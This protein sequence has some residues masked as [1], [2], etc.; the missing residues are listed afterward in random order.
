MRNRGLGNDKCGFFCRLKNKIKAN[1]KKLGVALLTGNVFVIAPVLAKT[2]FPE[3]FGGLNFR[4][5]PFSEDNL[6]DQEKQIIENWNDNQF[7][8]FSLKI[9]NLLTGKNAQKNEA[10]I[11]MKIYVD[12]L[13]AQLEK[14]VAI[15]GLSKEAIAIKL[16]YVLDVFT[17][18]TATLAQAPDQLTLVV[19]SKSLS[20]F[21]DVQS[22]LVYMPTS[23][24]VKL[25]RIDVT[26]S[27][28]ELGPKKST[29]AAEELLNQNPNNQP[30]VDI[31]EIK[32]ESKGF[33]KLL[34]K[35]AVATGIGL[36]IREILKKKNN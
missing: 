35:I 6:T 31:V 34:P 14:G 20:V 18:A 8:P 2:F 33:A 19:A 29:K 22:D 9:E 25:L 26:D 23:V 3:T 15:A 24:E 30:P 17:D 10:L 11:A 4:K 27:K 12:S 21:S 7:L 5:K 1:W 16:T 13:T 36:L 32:T 28:L